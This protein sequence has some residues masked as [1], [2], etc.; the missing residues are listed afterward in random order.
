MENAN[1]NFSALGFGRDVAST[2]YSYEAQGEEDFLDDAIVTDTN[3]YD[4]DGNMT[5][6]PFSSDS[7]GNDIKD[8]VGLE[9]E[10]PESR[11]MLNRISKYIFRDLKVGTKEDALKVFA[12]LME[13][14]NANSTVPQNVLS[15][16]D[17]AI[18]RAQ[19]IHGIQ[20]EYQRRQRMEDPYKQGSW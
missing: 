9:Q 7:L 10:D 1:G 19:K 16:V 17:Q 2:G 6:E 4:E 5:N 8:Q 12:Q 13:S 20:A 11:D 3:E 18:R 14:E 15:V